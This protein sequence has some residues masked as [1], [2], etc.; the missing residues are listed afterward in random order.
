[1]GF[2]TDA[3]KTVVIGCEGESS[4][5]ALDDIF[6]ITGVTGH[7]WTHPGGQMSWRKDN[8][9]QQEQLPPLSTP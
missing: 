5:R 2:R 3:S 8:K 7:D 1:M 6:E 9:A 4:L